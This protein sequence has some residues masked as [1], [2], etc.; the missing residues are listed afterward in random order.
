VRGRVREPHP[1]PEEIA[2][3]DVE[4]PVPVADGDV[5]VASKA[6]DLFVGVER[7]TFLAPPRAAV[8]RP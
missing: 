5:F 2:A 7:V 1:A 6:C 4:G 8:E 3:Q